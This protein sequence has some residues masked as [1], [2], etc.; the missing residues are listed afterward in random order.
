VNLL[1]YIKYKRRR[2]HFQY[3]RGG[4]ISQQKIELGIWVNLSF[5]YLWTTYFQWILVNREKKEY[6]DCQ[7][8]CL[9]LV[10]DGHKM[11]DQLAWTSRKYGSQGHGAIRTDFTH[12]FCIQSTIQCNKE[13]FLI[14]TNVYLNYKL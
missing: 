7:F 6:A 14:F 8:N 1:V 3:L 10:V 11:I 5:T 12:C 9:R 13:H 4:K 2:L